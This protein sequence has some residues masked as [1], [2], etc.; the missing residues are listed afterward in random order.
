MVINREN[1]ERLVLELQHDDD[2]GKR[3]ALQQIFQNMTIGMN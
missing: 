3:E 1:I 2:D